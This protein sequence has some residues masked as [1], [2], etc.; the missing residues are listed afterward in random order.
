MIEETT[1]EFDIYAWVVL[2]LLIFFARIADVSLGTL[3]FVFISRGYKKLAPLLGFV[4]V[5]IW[6]L[7]VREVMM[8]LRNII[9][10]LAYGIGFAMGNY[11]GMWLE[12]KLSIGIVLVRVVLRTDPAELKEFMRKN[13]YGFTIVE[14]EG[15]KERVKILFTILK[16]KNL[17]HVISALSTYN[18]HAFY[19]VE[20]IKSVSEG[21]FP[22]VEKT[23][24]SKLFRKHR[25]SK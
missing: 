19:S 3:R 13:D 4:E 23:V 24:F 21:I 6:V 25:K 2:P 18:S 10:L 16:R 15:T 8:N 5:L 7:A 20:S 14:G 22:G 1:M 12:E 9:C 11:L 17:D